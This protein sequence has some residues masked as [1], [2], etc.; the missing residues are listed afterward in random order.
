[1]RIHNWILTITIIYFVLIAYLSGFGPLTFGAGLG[2]LAYF[3]LII[4]WI[5]VLGIY[6][7][8]IRLKNIVL[9]PIVLRLIIVALMGSCVYTTLELTYWRDGLYP[10]NGRILMMSHE[11]FLQIEQE[12]LNAKVDSLEQVVRTNPNDYKS[13][14]RQ[15]YILN[16]IENWDL[17]IETFNKA[18]ETNL[19]IY[20]PLSFIEECDP[21]KSLY[22]F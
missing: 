17:A 1:M 4:L 16:E 5:I 11:E 21:I 8:I 9:K 12:K 2:D 13:R 10:W 18:I 6:F 3:F 15:G 22:S 14:T 19:T 7:L 20:K